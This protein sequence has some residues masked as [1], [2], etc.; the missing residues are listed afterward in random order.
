MHEFWT[1]SIV[2][3]LYINM[4]NYTSMMVGEHELQTFKI[5]VDLS[6][7]LLS[8]DVLFPQMHIPIM[9]DKWFVQMRLNVN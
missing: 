3:M 9:L 5:V 6:L 8:C 4:N 7:L 1:I 2:N